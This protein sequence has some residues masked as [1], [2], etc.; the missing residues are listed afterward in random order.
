M[1]DRAPRSRDALDHPSLYEAA[2]QRA[3][4][5]VALEGHLGER[6]GR[7]IGA[8]RDGPKGVPLGKGRTHRPQSAVHLSVMTVL[9][10]LDDSAQIA[11]SNR[12]ARKIS[13]ISKLA[14]LNLLIYTA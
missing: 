3:K 5:L 10:L 12:H 13:Q 7:R 14:Y 11:K 4:R 1:P 9:K 6:V 2:A 8:C